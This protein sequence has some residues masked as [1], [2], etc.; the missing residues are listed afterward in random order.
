MTAMGSVVMHVHTTTDRFEGGGGKYGQ[1]REKGRQK[2]DVGG[3]YREKMTRIK[4]KK[5][6]EKGKEVM[7]DEEIKRETKEGEKGKN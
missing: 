2:R 1:R 4:V 7:V 5:D 3:L 6:K